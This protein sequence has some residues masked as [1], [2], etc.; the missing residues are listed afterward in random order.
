MRRFS[1]VC[2][3]PFLPRR[4]CIFYSH[5]FKRCTFP[6]CTADSL[7]IGKNCSCDNAIG[8][9]GAKFNESRI[10]G[11]SFCEL[12]GGGSFPTI[13]SPEIEARLL[14]RHGEICN[15]DASHL[16]MHRHARSDSRFRTPTDRSV[17][18][19]LYCYSFP[20]PD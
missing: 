9:R 17:S 18:S 4:N 6:G 20:S 15:A 3:S 2:S 12:G 11:K 14:S 8:L 7:G 16:H 19:P 10:D 1:L 13:R 5:L